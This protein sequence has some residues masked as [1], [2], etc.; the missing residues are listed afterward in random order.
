MP[1]YELILNHVQCNVQAARIPWTPRGALDA[2]DEEQCLA[3]QGDGADGSKDLQLKFER[4]PWP[5]TKQLSKSSIELTR[6]PD[7][8]HSADISPRPASRPASMPDSTVL[9]DL[10]QTI[11]ES[12]ATIPVDGEPAEATGTTAAEFADS[13]DAS[14]DS[15]DPAFAFEKHR[16]VGEGE[17]L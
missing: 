11:E 9:A 10:H 5:L 7:C 8:D 12:T 17:W 6:G 2:E 14:A 15:K 1:L 4:I 16:Q 3:L 13:D